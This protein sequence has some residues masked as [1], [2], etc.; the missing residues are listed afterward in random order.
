MNH[1][2][3]RQ[4]RR[5]TLGLDQVR[6]LRRVM[7]SHV[8]PLT[9]DGHLL[10]GGIAATIGYLLKNDYIH[11]DNGHYAL[12]DAVSFSLGLSTPEPPRRR[13]R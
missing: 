6:T 8:A 4:S 9:F 2:A 5:P 12:T 3:E 11:D 10:G 1:L 7:N 13:R